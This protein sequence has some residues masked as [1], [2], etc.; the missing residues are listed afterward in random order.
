MKYPIYLLIFISVHTSIYGQTDSLEN[1]NAK[2]TIHVISYE[3]LSG[4]G[5]TFSKK[6]KSSNYVCYGIVGSVFQGMNL[7]FGYS[8]AYDERVFREYGQ[9][10]IRF[11]RLINK[12][13]NFEYGLYFSGGID[14]GNMDDPY[15][16]YGILTSLF[17][18]F[19]KFKIGHIVQIGAQHTDFQTKFDFL[20]T[21]T[22]ISIRVYL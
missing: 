7:K 1:M 20:F 9:I 11:M 19:P 5:Y 17:Y 8:T 6:R 12:N 21:I 18:G 15:L 10:N 14:I 2:K 16:S 22:P 4:I 3:P 13:I